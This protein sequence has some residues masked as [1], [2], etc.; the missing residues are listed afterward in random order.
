VKRPFTMRFG[1]TPSTAAQMP[2]PGSLSRFLGLRVPIAIDPAAA[3]DGLR[4]HRCPSCEAQ[5]PQT[6]RKLQLRPGEDRWPYAEAALVLFGVALLFG[7]ALRRFGLEKEAFELWEWS[8]WLLMAVVS[9]AAVLVGLV[10]L[11]ARFLVKPTAVTLSICAGC[12][13]RARD[14]DLLRIVA[15]VGYHALA[16]LTLGLTLWGLWAPAAVCFEGETCL[17]ASV[18]AFSAVTNVVFGVFAVAM[19]VRW[20]LHVERGRREP[21]LRN[22]STDVLNLMVPQ[23]WTKHISGLSGTR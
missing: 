6:E 21:A 13:L 12:S 14:R 4:G 8:G 3:D 2:T 10:R 19:A 18:D 16:T 22:R 17:P 1:S 5:R 11:G 15:E 20:V 23:S 7:D 9:S